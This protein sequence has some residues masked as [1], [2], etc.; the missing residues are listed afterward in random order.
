MPAEIIANCWKSCDLTGS[1]AVECGDGDTLVASD[2]A[3]LD[4]VLTN[5]PNS[6]R[7][8]SIS[9][10]LNADDGD[11]LEIFS[12]EELAQNAARELQGN[13]VG[14]THATGDSGDEVG[15]SLPMQEQIMAVKKCLLVAEFQQTLDLQLLY[16]LRILLRA[17]RRQS[18]SG[19]RQTTLS[20]FFSA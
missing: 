4:A 13:H 12:E 8:M 2:T 5:L 7:R 11:F 3:A 10:I 9:N 17:L 20:F 18:V 14:N 15:V 19:L 16:H 1:E 6:Q